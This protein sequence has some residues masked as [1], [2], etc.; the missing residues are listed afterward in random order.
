MVRQPYLRNT[1]WPIL[2]GA[3][4]ISYALRF[5][6]I[7]SA[8]VFAVRSKILASSAMQTM[9]PRTR[10]SAAVQWS[11]AIQLAVLSTDVDDV[12]RG[13]VT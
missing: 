9:E 11:A 5:I 2:P 6:A 10:T 7:R 1:R 12:R 13:L 3:S 8:P 4:S